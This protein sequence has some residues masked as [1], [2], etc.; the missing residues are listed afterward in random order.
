[1][2]VPSVAMLVITAGNVTAPGGEAAK[3]SQARKHKQPHDGDDADAD[4][5]RAN[6]PSEAA[7]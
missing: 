5:A 3:P 7:L 6:I 4:D 2:A 1:M